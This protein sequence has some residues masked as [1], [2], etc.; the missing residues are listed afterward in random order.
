MEVGLGEGLGGDRF[1]SGGFGMDRLRKHVI[2]LGRL[3]V[4]TGWMFPGWF[5]ID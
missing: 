1:V 2:Q 5:G 3:K 4:D